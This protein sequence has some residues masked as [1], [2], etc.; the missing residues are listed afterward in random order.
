MLACKDEECKTRRL[1]TFTCKTDKTHNTKTGQAPRTS[2]ELAPSRVRETAAGP[3]RNQ[4]TVRTSD[5]ERLGLA[6]KLPHISSNRFHTTS[7]PRVRETE[8]DQKGTSP[9]RTSDRERP[10]AAVASHRRRWSLRSCR[11]VAE[12]S[13]A[14]TGM[15][16]V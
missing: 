14:S 16:V 7:L 13:G 2:T 9:V 8:E 12:A 3:K 4:T 6:H 5:R 11:R 1:K 10:G 15:Q